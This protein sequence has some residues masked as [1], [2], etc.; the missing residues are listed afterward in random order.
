MADY[1]E[2]CNCDQALELCKLLAK[3]R[4]LASGTAKGAQ[5]LQELNESWAFSDPMSEETDP[6]RQRTKDILDYLRSEV[7]ASEK[8]NVNV[9]EVVHE[10]LDDLEKRYGLA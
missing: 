1:E 9:D 7:R 10:L 5:W 4:V 3:A 6:V 8:L 2:Q